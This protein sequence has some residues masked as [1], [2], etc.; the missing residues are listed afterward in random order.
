MGLSDLSKQGALVLVIRLVIRLK[1]LFLI[2][3]F[4]SFVLF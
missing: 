3:I 4:A 1:I 2:R